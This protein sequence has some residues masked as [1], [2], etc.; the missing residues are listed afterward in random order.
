MST[1]EIVEVRDRRELPFFQAARHRQPGVG[2]ERFGC[3]VEAEL[4]RDG[5]TIAG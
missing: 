1:G 3:V 4:R 2:V 5:L